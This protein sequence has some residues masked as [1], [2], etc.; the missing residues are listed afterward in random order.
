M[1]RFLENECIIDISSLRLPFCHSHT[2]IYTYTHTHTQV[3]LVAGVI[4]QCANMANDM[5]LVSSSMNGDLFLAR[6][7]CS[8]QGAVV[9]NATR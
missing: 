2:Y 4:S 5:N 7:V 9:L 6:M 1:G 8:D 3:V